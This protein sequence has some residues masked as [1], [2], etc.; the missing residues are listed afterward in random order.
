MLRPS[1][2]VLC[3]QHFNTSSISLKSLNS[4][5][6]LVL[7]LKEIYT[8]LGLAKTENKEQLAERIYNYV[9]PTAE[10]ETRKL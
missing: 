10:V 2:E 1:S 8:N 4:K 7:K 3:Q 9:Y 6:Y 5:Q